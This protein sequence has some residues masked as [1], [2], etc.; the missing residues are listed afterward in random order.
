MIQSIENSSR[1]KIN[2]MNALDKNALMVNE[3]EAK[4]NSRVYI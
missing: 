2:L 1:E 4:V 3:L